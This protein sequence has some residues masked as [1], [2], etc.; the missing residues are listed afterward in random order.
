MV[1]TSALSGTLMV[2]ASAR[3][4]TEFASGGAVMVLASAAWT[5]R[6]K[7]GRSCAGA[8]RSII[9]S[10]RRLSHI[11]APS[12]ISRWRRARPSRKRGRKQRRRPWRRCI[13]AMESLTTAAAASR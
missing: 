2:A 13:S 12:C 7:D 8:K 3:K 6:L 11:D 4:G 9:A 10:R 1:P 5:R